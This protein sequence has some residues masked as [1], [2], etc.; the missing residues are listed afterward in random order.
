MDEYN[1]L[2]ERIRDC[3]KYKEMLAIRESVWNLSGKTDFSVY[4][5]LRKRV[6]ERIEEFAKPNCEEVEVSI[7]FGSGATHALDFRECRVILGK[8]KSLCEYLL[9]NN[10]GAEDIEIKPSDSSEKKGFGRSTAYSSA[11]AK[12][13]SASA[14]PK[15]GILQSRIE[16]VI[17]LAQYMNNTYSKVIPKISSDLGDIVEKLEILYSRVTSNEYQS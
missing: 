10:P 16:N 2:R 9:W 17:K 5:D 14:N 3:I 4:V 1:A 13:S 12:N 8:G 11:T 7:I 15:L 6:D